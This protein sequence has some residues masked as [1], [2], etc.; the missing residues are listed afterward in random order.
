MAVIL[1]MASN[2]CRDIKIPT[3]PKPATPTASPTDTRVM[4]PT[5]TPTHSIT[6]T[7]TM[8][9]T[10]TLTGTITPTF[11][12]T[13]TKVVIRVNCG[14]APDC[15]WCGVIAGHTD[16][17]GAYWNADKAYVAG[18]WGYRSG[19]PGYSTDPV[20]NSSPDSDDV[21]YYYDRSGSPNNLLLYR[22]TVPN[23]AYKVNLFFSEDFFNAAGL[24]VFDMYINSVKVLSNFDIYATVGHDWAV[25]YSFDSTVTTGY[26]DVSGT[27]SVSTGAFIS[28]IEILQQ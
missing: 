27:A 17:H 7:I 22:F 6:G 11:T 25:N 5:V 18:S 20:A 4:S 24:R 1:I 21:L 8:T 23:G 3:L 14:R 9:G 28:G 12:I 2:A 15:S 19:A 26:I 10:I 13:P 16:S